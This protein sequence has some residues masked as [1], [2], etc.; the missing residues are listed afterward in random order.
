MKPSEFLTALW[1]ETPRAPVLVW[2]LPDRRSHWLASPQEADQDW[3]ERDVYT[4]VSLPHPDAK[5]PATRR[6]SAAEAH[7]IPGLWADVDYTDDAHTKPGLPAQADALRVLMQDVETPTILVSSGHGYQPWWMFDEPWILDTDEDRAQAQMLVR[8]WQTRLAAALDAAMDSTHDLARVLRVPGTLNRK[9][10]P[11][12]VTAEVTGARRT[13]DLWV[14]EAT[15]AR[16]S[17]SGDVQGSF[18]LGTRTPAYTIANGL[19]LTADR[20]PVSERRDILR[21]AFPEVDVVLDEKRTKGDRSPSGYDMSTANYAVQAGFSDQE[22]VDLCIYRRVRHGHDPKLRLAYWQRTLA[23]ARLDRPATAAELNEQDLSEL[24]GLG[25]ERVLEI[26]DPD[27]PDAPTYRLLSSRG[28]LEVPSVANLT[29]QQLFREA[30]YQQVRKWPPALDAQAWNTF[31]RRIMEEVEEIAPGH[32]DHP[33]SKNEPGETREWVEAYLRQAAPSPNAE[34]GDK[35]G[36][37]FEHEGGVCF[38]LH[39]FRQWLKHSRDE[40]VKPQ[41]LASRLRDIDGEQIRIRS[42]GAYHRFWRLGS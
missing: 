38:P 25:F 5:T 10:E 40:R 14:Q 33:R 6:V 20:E 1:G 9:G 3:G 28:T 15:N 30:C 17:D 4:S 26:R 42:G 36:V 24:G 2:T 32:P 7:A 8:W 18:T 35:L 22:I 27:H 23:A 29:R 11:V 19:I 16:V 12:P 41:K 39:G 37:P 34:E 13:R 31:V 21:E